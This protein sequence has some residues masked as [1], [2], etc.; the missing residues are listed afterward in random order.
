MDDES[1]NQSSNYLDDIVFNQVAQTTGLDRL[2]LDNGTWLGDIAQTTKAHDALVA[3]LSAK[4]NLRP[5]QVD[6]FRRYTAQKDR[7]L[8]EIINKLADL[9]DV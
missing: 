2:L 9:R 3:A 4:L 1:T 8:G 5:S 6:E 7:N